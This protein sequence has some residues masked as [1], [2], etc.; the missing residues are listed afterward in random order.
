MHALFCIQAVTSGT[1]PGFID[2]VL[3]FDSSSLEEDN[4]ISQM[5]MAAKNLVFYGD[6]T[7]LK[8]FPE[9]FIRSDGTT[10]FYVSD[11]TEV[12]KFGNFL[13]LLIHLQRVSVFS[14]G[15]V[16]VELQGE[17]DCKQIQTSKN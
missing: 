1:I 11:Y 2:V 9:H 5:K 3:N 8:L 14:P 10:S 6:D 4:L 15:A 13:L 7:W 17:L 16:G 12:C